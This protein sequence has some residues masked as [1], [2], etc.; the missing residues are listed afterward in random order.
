[1]QQNF[2]SQNLG[3]NGVKNGLF[4]LFIEKY[5]TDFADS[6]SGEGY[7]GNKS[8]CI[9]WDPAEFWFSKYG[10]K[11]GQKWALLTVSGKVD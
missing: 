8:C 7:Y 6:L 9:I 1:M 3:S 10:V 5:L 11:W 2:G 4:R